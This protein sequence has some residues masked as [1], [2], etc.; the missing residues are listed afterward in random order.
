[1]ADNSNAKPFRNPAALEI[2]L[3]KATHVFPW[4]HF[5]HAEGG[6]E[7]IHLEFSTRNVVITGR[8]LDKLIPRVISQQVGILKELSRAD[9]FGQSSEC[10]IAKITVE[11]YNG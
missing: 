5:L 10:H 1:M 7:E 9:G 3:A 8:G 4:S 2:V 11:K 6:S